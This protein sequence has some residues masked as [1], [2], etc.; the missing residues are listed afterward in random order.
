[1]ES[2]RP[3]IVIFELGTKDLGKSRPE[4]VGSQLEEFAR[5]LHV[6]FEVKIVCVN[7]IIFR[8]NRPD[9]NANVCLLNRYL[10]FTICFFLAPS[11]F[12]EL[13]KQYLLG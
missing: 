9:F 1:M 7:Q 8:D 5:V 10:Y 6:N 13:L 2:F 11:W 12:L 3:D 4:I